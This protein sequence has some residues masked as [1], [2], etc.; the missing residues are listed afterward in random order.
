MPVPS[1]GPSRG[2]WSVPPQLPPG[3]L[4][5]WRV[6]LSGPDADRVRARAGRVLSADEAARAGRLVLREDRR[7]WVAARV[8]L[9]TL[10]AG[11]LGIS[12]DRVTLEHGRHG[13]PGLPGQGRDG[14]SFNLSHSRDR[15]LLAVCRGA[16]VGVD[17]EHLSAGPADAA[18]LD[19]LA[20]S[21]LA[22]EELRA[23]LRLPPERRRAALLRRWTAK[24]A[25]LKAT[26]RGVTLSAARRLV[27]PDGSGTPRGLPGDWTLLRLRPG[28]GFTGAVT[29]R[30]RDWNL[31]CTDFTT[32]V[33]AEPRPAVR[34]EPRPAVRAES[35]PA[36]RAGFTPV[37]RDDPTCRDARTA[38][39]STGDVR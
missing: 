11:Y 30:G 7:R 27:V 5:V 22:P 12:P 23:Y 6:P 39:T 19:D 18:G 26:G 2:A 3:V 35:R 17:L 36:V 16:P 33:R 28:Q 32:T 8:A 4:H 1:P 31:A 37:V 20:V 10:L 13:K 29:V 38:L 25:V 24:E 15:A 9:R 34:A 14:L 21:M